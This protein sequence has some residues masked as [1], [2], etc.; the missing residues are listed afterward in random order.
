MANRTYLYAERPHEDGN[1]RI[2][3]I[4]EFSSGIPLAYRLLCSVNTER[5]P[6]KIFDDHP[7]DETGEIIG[8][9]AFRG[10]FPEGREILLQFM[11]R[12]ADTNSK[13]LHLPEDTLAEEF[14][15]TR[16]EL[17]HE[18]LLGCTHFWLEPLEVLA[19]GDNI[20]DELESL[21]AAIPQTESEINYVLDMWESGDFE[22]YNS[23]QEYFYSLGFGSWSDILYFQFQNPDN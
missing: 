3:S 2:F 8:P 10:S 5:V 6:S 18:R 9:G 4:G 23:A 12:L 1:S 7:N 15:S 22:P 13:N 19:L 14:A 20:P 11:E 17:F 21:A 16:K